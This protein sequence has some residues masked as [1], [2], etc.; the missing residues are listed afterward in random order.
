MVNLCIKFVTGPW[1][2]SGKAPCARLPSKLALLPSLERRGGIPF[3]PCR[4]GGSTALAQ[5]RLLS[6]PLWGSVL[7]L[8]SPLLFPPVGCRPGC[9][10]CAQGFLPPNRHSAP[11]LLLKM[12]TEIQ[13]LTQGMP[14]VLLQPSLLRLL[15]LCF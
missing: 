8:L 5:P 14:S 1:G 15:L 12:Q 2:S 3:S 13:A 7:T 11:R 4:E 9:L 10:A 6:P